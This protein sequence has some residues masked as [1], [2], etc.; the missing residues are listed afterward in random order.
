M[1]IG[2][3]GYK[4]F[5]GSS[6]LKFESKKFKIS[7]VDLPSDW[8]IL[9]GSEISNLNCFDLLLNA[10]VTADI[11][12]SFENSILKRVIDYC[13]WFKSKSIEK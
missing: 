5:I 7:P 4:G 1:R 2:V 10:A 9:S 11:I 6:L 12:S 3:F 13:N 8:N